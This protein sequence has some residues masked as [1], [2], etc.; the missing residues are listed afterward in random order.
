MGTIEFPCSCGYL[1]VMEVGSKGRTTC[2]KCKKK[3][4]SLF[5]KYL[6][7]KKVDRQIGR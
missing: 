7:R 3:Y 1:I 2:P 5:S 4:R 6:D